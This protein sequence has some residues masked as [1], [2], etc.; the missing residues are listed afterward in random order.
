MTTDIELKRIL[1]NRPD[2]AALITD[3]KMKLRRFKSDPPQYEIVCQRIDENTPVTVDADGIWSW[4]TV[5]KA[6]FN[7][8]SVVPHDMLPKDWHALLALLIDNCEDIEE[9]GASEDAQVLDLLESWLGGHNRTRWSADDLDRSPLQ[10]EGYHY[11]RI[12][13]FENGAL[14]ASN[15]PFHYQRYKVPRPKLHKILRKAGGRSVVK[16]FR[17]RDNVRLWE[18]AEGFNRPREK[19]EGEIEEDE[20]E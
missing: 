5:Q 15:S 17:G 6:V 10:R 12:N 13:A 11:F 4:A 7:T 9:P 8:W 16:A 3:G 2:F 14:F 18:I 19:S 20:S 1:D